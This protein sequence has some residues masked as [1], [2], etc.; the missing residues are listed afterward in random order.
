MI[1][2]GL[3]SGAIV[4][5][6]PQVKYEILPKFT[7]NNKKYQAVHYISD[8]NT[9]DRNGIETVIDIKGLLKPMDVIKHKM[10]LS[11]Y[12][13]M[14][15]LLLGYSRLDGG[16]VSLETISQGRKERKKLKI[17]KEN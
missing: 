17:L 11:K 15:F 3:E 16:W 13:D 8:F 12:P 10:L 9:I 6:T 5:C 4:S 2:V 14:N 7:H 1:E